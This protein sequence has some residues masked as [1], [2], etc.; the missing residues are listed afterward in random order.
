MYESTQPLSA[1]VSAAVVNYQTPDLTEE[2]LR[3]FRRHYPDVELLVIDNGSQDS[4]PDLI[5]R[6]ADELTLQTIFLQ[7]N[8]YHGPAMHIAMSELQTPWV[9]LLDSDTIT[10]KGGFLEAMLE[11]GASPKVYGAGK[12]VHVDRR[13][14]RADDGIPVL[15]SAYMLI[16]RDI[17]HRLPPFVHHGLPALQNFEAAHRA[18]YHLEPFDIERY[19]RHLGRGTAARFGYGLGFRSRLDFLLKKLGL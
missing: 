15:V 8:R 10:E 17:Y 12:V 5:R 2:A 11:L 16:N 18:G 14:F 1:H 7:R 6:L 13:G 4:S 9:F 3:S 19:V